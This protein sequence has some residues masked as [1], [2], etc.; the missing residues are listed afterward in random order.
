VV[1]AI[2]TTSFTTSAIMPYSNN[3]EERIAFSL[4]P[5]AGAVPERVVYSLIPSP[6]VIV[7][8]ISEYNQLVF[9]YTAARTDDRVVVRSAEP[10]EYMLLDFNLQYRD[11][12]LEG[13]PFAIPESDI[14][15]YIE[16]VDLVLDSSSTDVNY[17][18]Q[19]MAITNA[20]VTLSVEAGIIA[21]AAKT[22][23][24]TRG[25]SF[26]GLRLVVE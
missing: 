17:L 9:Q 18:N 1:I 3:L 10:G 23:S 24:F 8:D 19:R 15:V 6:A 2:D 14:K 4:R 25:F 21:I 26:L 7:L 16:I 12:S 11:D 13:L 20:Q 22:R 5:G